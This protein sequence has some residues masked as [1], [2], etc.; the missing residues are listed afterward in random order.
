MTQLHGLNF[1]FAQTAAY[2]EYQQPISLHLWASLMHY[3]ATEEMLDDCI[4]DPVDHL[5]FC[6]I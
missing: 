3:Q 6:V 1:F 4:V 5:F 2:Y